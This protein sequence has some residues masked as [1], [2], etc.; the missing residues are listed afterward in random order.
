MARFLSQ[1]IFDIAGLTHSSG[2]SDK[3]HAYWRAGARDTVTRSLRSDPTIVSGMFNQETGTTS[4]AIALDE[5]HTIMSVLR[6]NYPCSKISFAESNLYDDSTSGSIHESSIYNPVWYVDTALSNTPTIKVLPTSSTSIKAELINYDGIDDVDLF[7]ETESGGLS[8]TMETLLVLYVAIRILNDEMSTQ[9][10]NITFSALTGTP[11]FTAFD[12]ALTHA[13]DLIDNSG[14]I[15]GLTSDAVDFIEEGDTEQVAVVIAAA[16]Q[17]LERAAVS[18]GKFEPAIAEA[19]AYMESELKELE[20]L[21]IRK[22][23]L[24]QEYY[25]YFG[26][27][28]KSKE[29]ADG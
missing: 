5:V 24:M 2:D 26:Q 15:S 18:V 6:D 9:A 13:Q 29:R 22:S 8:I 19:K 28:Q 1:K 16:K 20:Q 17:E 11:G 4:L 3:V 25:G 10:S 14:G 27:Q 21:A 7:D 23:Q 12:D